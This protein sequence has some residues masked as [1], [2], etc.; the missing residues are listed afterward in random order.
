MSDILKDGLKI[1]SFSDEQVEIISPKIEQYIKELILFNSAY[2]LVNTDNH[3]EIV[4]RHILDSLSA[5]SQ[6]KELVK[7][8]SV[9]KKVN[10]NDSSE[11][12]NQFK[13]KIIIGDI[14]SGGGLPGIPLG[15][16]MPEC[17]FVLVERMSKRCAFLENVVA[18]LGLTNVAVMNV[19]AEQVKSGSIDIA[20]FRAFRPLD[21]KMIKTLLNIIP[22][23][24]V[25]AAYK[26]KLD[27]IKEEMSAINYDENLYSVIPLKV[28]FLTED[29]EENRERNLVL[30]SK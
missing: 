22:S 19:E 20:V 10:K 15:I 18:I 16:A 28:P 17:K 7:K 14:G 2:N 25:L 21:K 9:Q 29:S 30:I 5:V 23:T 4:I 1:L 24:G 3:D 12:N 27:K 26:A 8:V 6:L 13:D 11:S